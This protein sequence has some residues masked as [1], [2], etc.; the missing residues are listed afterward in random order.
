MITYNTDLYPVQKPISTILSQE[1]KIEAW[2]HQYGFSYNPFQFTDSERDINLDEHFVEF[3]DFDKILKINDQIIFARTGDGKTATRLRLQTFYRDAVA[4]QRVFAFSY[5]IPQ[6]LAAQPPHDLRG[7][8]K[9]LL[10]AAVSHLFV[11]LALRGLDLP[12]LRHD[13]TAIPLARRFAFYFHEYYALPDTWQ[14]D[15]QQAIVDRSMRQSITSL[16]PL[17]DDLESLAQ[18]GTLNTVWASRWLELLTTCGSPS[19]AQLPSQPLTRWFDLCQLLQMIG[20]QKILILADGVDTRPTHASSVRQW[21]V[22][23][24]SENEKMASIVR[25]KAVVEPMLD[26]MQTRKL[27][28]IVTWKLFLPSEL[29]FPLIPLLPNEFPHAILWWDYDRLRQLLKFRLSA[30]TQGRITTL[31]QISDNDV[32]QDLETYLVIQANSSPRYLIHYINKLFGVHVDQLDN[33]SL[34]GKLSGKALATLAYL[35][36]SAP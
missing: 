12:A 9:P 24:S 13:E 23:N 26:A 4:D 6:E 7:H 16:E 15:L 10:T 14:E 18:L 2:L 27:G 36:H 22:H 19:E 30:A 33:T 34:P 21:Q 35:S 11:F 31:L 3:P 17:F 29:Y 32:P 20:L 1:A 28:D 8:L 5:L 25:M